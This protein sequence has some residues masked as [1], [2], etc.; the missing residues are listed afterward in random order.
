MS[1]VSGSVSTQLKAVSHAEK[2]WVWWFGS[3]NALL[4]EA[5]DFFKSAPFRLRHKVIR[6]D[7]RTE[8]KQ[9]VQPESPA[10]TEQLQKR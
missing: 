10:R 5:F 7:P 3:A 8:R 4:P 9:A 1:R 6:E 2:L